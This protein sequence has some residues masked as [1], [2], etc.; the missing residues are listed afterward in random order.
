LIEEGLSPLKNPTE[1]NNR[2]NNLEKNVGSFSNE[3]SDIKN[4]L[5]PTNPNEVLKVVRL[6][7]KFELMLSQISKLESN[8]KEFRIEMDQKIQH[9]YELVDSNVDRIVGIIKWVGLLLIPIILN[10]LRD[11]FDIRLRDKPQES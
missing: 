2:L 10:I 6:G 9:N 3:I 11:L 1:L 8:L 7:D 5:N 4:A